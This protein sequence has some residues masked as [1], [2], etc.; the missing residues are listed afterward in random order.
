MDLSWSQYLIILPLVFLAGFVDAVA[1]GGGLISLPAY[2]MSGLPIH[3]VIGTNK[4]S[5]C[6]GTTLATVKYALD[7][8][9][10][11]RPA[12]AGMVCALV[13]SSMGASLALYIDPAYF[14]LIILIVLP[15]TAA[16]VFLKKSIVSDKPPYEETTTMGIVMACALMMGVYDGFYGP[17]T[18]T[19]LLLLLT[20]IAHMK[21][22]AANGVT[23]VINLSTNVAALSVFLLNDTVMIGLGLLAGC[24]NIAGNYLGARYFERNGAGS[25]K[26][27]ILVVLV[28][29]FAKT[30]WD[31]LYGN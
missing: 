26:K 31:Y 14:R 10:S 25:V 17:G 5:S 3:Y 7:G 27:L 30:A 11:W 1:G 13:G 4:L 9:V 2:M 22:T 8:Y 24:F 15:L 23:K 28:I 16:Y 6:M 20:G 19:F 12:L 21:V 18:G 29:F